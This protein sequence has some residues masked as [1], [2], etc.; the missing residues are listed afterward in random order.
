LAVP[1]QFNKAFMQRQ[2]GKYFDHIVIIAMENKDYNSVIGNIADAPFLNQLVAVGSTMSQYNDNRGTF[3]PGSC[4]A[5]CYVAFMAGFCNPCVSDGYAEGSLNIPNLVADRLVPAGFTWEAFCENTC[6]RGPDHFPFLGFTD[7]YQS[8]NIVFTCSSCADVWNPTSYQQFV[9]AANLNPAPNFLWFTPTD[10]HNMHS[11]PNCTNEC[12]SSTTLNVCIQKGDQY[13]QTML[14]GGGS[15]SNPASGS[16]LASAIFKNDRTLLYIWWDEGSN[17]HNP[18]NILYGASSKS[19][20]T[21]SSTGYNEYAALRIIEDNWQLSTMTSN[22]AAASLGMSELFTPTGDFGSCSSLPQ[23]WNCGNLNA[24][25]GTGLSSIESNGGYHSKLS[26]V[27]GGNSQYAYATTQKGTFPWS[28]CQ[29][30]ASGVLGQ[31]SGRIATMFDPLSLPATPTGRFDIYLGLYYW[32]PG[33]AQSAHGQTYQC[34]ATQVRAEF[35]NGAFT[36]AINSTDFSAT[37]NLGENSA[38]AF[39]WNR[40]IGPVIVGNYYALVADVGSQCKQDEIAWGIST[41]V[42]CVLSGVEVGI[43]GFGFGNQSLNI[44]WGAQIIV[45]LCHLKGDVDQDGGKINILDAANFAIYFG[46]EVGSTQYALSSHL[47]NGNSASADINLDGQADI[48]DAAQLSIYY[49]QPC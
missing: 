26:N 40:T 46:S 10:C 2:L 6:H 41:T 49:D 48:L 17:T 24:Q 1:L 47:A 30:P 36:P 28:P 5:E 21:T 38:N 23:G 39:G 35:K 4:S 19:G 42:T 33:G 29:A 8:P 25:G 11:D 14:V 44:L 45:S 16:L 3:P 12:T 13:L 15:I 34:L 7:T 9:S 31:T 22:D 18:P 43:E 20:Y 32:L 27:S 37:Y